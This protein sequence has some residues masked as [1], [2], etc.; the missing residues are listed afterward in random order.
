[1]KRITKLDKS[2]MLT[3]RFYRLHHHSENRSFKDIT[4]SLF[5]LSQKVRPLVWSQ[6]RNALSVEAQ[7]RGLLSLA[8]KIKNLFNPTTVDI[9]DPRIKGGH[10]YI[11]ILHGKQR[12]KEN[13][14]KKVSEE[15]HKKITEY[16][17]MC[18]EP[19]VLG[20][21][22]LAYL[23]GMRP[24]EMLKME[25]K[26]EQSAIFIHC[27]KE[28][29]KG[30]RGLSRELT[31]SRGEY[32]ILQWAYFAVQSEEQ[33]LDRSGDLC[34]PDR[35]M[36]RIQ[37]R[38]ADKMK[39][40]FPRRKNRITLYSYR[41]QMGSNLKASGFDHIT[42]SAIMGHQCVNSV[43]DYG[44]GK[45]ATRLPSM[46]VS[47]ESKAGVRQTEKRNFKEALSKNNKPKI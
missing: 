34:D 20:A 7:T 19:A 16:L 40:L 39:T 43:D 47:A 26:P 44:N 10:K 25:L 18:T 31:F 22:L 36:K 2:L 8:Q 12:K 24:A 33:R 6:Y 35:T 4:D 1:M 38:L 32:K 28:S 29:E 41:H 14:C 42:V 5:E 15:D 17:I 27:V 23:T 46:A 3:E 21:V 13:R 45:S 37:N 9:Q 11:E 30:D